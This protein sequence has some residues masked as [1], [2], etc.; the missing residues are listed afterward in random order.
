[1]PLPSAATDHIQ[2]RTYVQSRSERRASEHA[3]KQPRAL[4]IDV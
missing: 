3:S 2:L 1:M 4:I